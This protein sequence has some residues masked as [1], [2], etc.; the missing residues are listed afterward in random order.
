MSYIE[1][2]LVPGES[3]V[4]K[5]KLHWWVIVNLLFNLMIVA[6]LL[7]IVGYV[8]IGTS[9]TQ[10]SRTLVN[11]SGTV[12]SSLCLLCGLPF[13][14]I[15][16]LFGFLAY[17]SAEF[18][19]T[20]RRVMIKTGIV[21]RHTLELNLRQIE[22]FR[23]RETIVGRIMGYKTI[24][25]TGSGGTNQTF[26]YVAQA[27]EF[28]KKVTELSTNSQPDYGYA[29]MP[30]PAP[31]QQW[32]SILDNIELPAENTQQL[33]QQATQ[34][35]QSGNRQAAGQIVKQLMQSDPGN[36]DVW[37]L[38]GYLSTSADKKKQAFERALRIDPTHK[39]ARQGLS[40]L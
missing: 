15:S 16:L 29:P 9:S 2:N 3:M 23:V 21:R 33:I 35:I 22:S 38:V 34:Y 28:Q 26:R 32:S 17:R 40:T 36:A 6:L 39:K 20:N 18:G 7:T 1:D 37:Y 11:S 14:F 19:L 5:T 4:F 27:R 24:V 13:V 12:F 30:A 8:L 10:N 25:L 31:R